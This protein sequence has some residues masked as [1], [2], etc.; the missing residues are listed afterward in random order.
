MTVRVY[1]TDLT[2]TSNSTL[3]RSGWDYVEDRTGDFQPSCRTF[4]DSGLSLSLIPWTLLQHI[5]DPLCRVISLH[6]IRL[7]PHR[8]DPLLRYIL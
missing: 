8:P 5:I 2:P 7:I 3:S 6:Q 4:R 1:D